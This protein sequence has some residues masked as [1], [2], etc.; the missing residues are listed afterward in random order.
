MAIILLAC[1]PCV[2]IVNC[3]GHVLYFGRAPRTKETLSNFRECQVGYP[4]STSV[5]SVDRLS[6]DTPV[7]GRH[8]FYSLMDPVRSLCYIGIRMG[9]G[10]I[11][12]TCCIL[13][14]TSCTNETIFDFY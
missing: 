1:R 8:N 13:G 3:L 12:H 6:T 9:H 11:C 4:I 5:P 14:R 7:L 2:V 10:I